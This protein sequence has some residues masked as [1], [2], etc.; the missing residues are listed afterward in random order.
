[1]DEGIPRAV[2]ITKIVRETP[3]IRTFRLSES[4]RFTPGQFVMVWVP[5]VDE[6]P[7]A[8]SAEDSISV[9][10]VG[11][12]TSAM[13]RLKAGDK[14]GIRG[15]FGNGFSAGGRVLTV[16]GGIGAAPLLPLAMQGKAEVFLQGAATG[17]ELPFGKALAGKTD[18]RVATDDG[19]RG[20]HGFV[21]DLLGDLN[22]K[23]FSTICACGPEP[24][25]R[26][27]LRRLEDEGI[28]DRGQFS[29]H[30]Y[31]K[32]G[33]GLCGSCAIDPSGMRV[34]REG[35]VFRGDE[36]AGTEFGKYSRDA[37]GRRVYLKN[38]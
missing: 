34:C 17:G 35:P 15:P 31:M 22:L 28:P 38:P 25:M 36:L 26:A 19:S 21:T 24:M 13:F 7:M 2:S 3:K 1:M 27:V 11:D 9:Q 12:A 30:R 29:L 33:V 14:L 6:I 18:L 23:E 20:H 37:S 16:A 4:F 32:C 8:L 10:E 5:G